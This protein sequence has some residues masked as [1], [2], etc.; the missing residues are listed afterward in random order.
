[1]QIFGRGYDG[2]IHSDISADG[3]HMIVIEE[4]KTLNQQ[5][6]HQY[7]LGTAFDLSTIKRVGSDLYN[8]ADTAM[9]NV[10]LIRVNPNGESYF[11]SEKHSSADA[12]NQKLR[13]YAVDSDY[14]V[15]FPTV[16]SSQP[17][18]YGDGA[19]PTTVSFLRLTSNDGTNVLITDHRE[20]S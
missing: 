10:P 15:T 16:T 20:I 3:H 8:V 14:K 13:V 9:N 12:G 1:M 4:A 19:D 7:F 6:I 11:L 2:F 5:R 17:L 18:G